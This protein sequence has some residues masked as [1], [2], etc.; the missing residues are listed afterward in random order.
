MT[1]LLMICTALLA[2]HSLLQSRGWQRWDG[3]HAGGGLAG[4]GSCRLP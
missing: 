1:A 4:G 2:V 3:A